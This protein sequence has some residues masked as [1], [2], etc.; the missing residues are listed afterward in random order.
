MKKSRGHGQ[1]SSPYYIPFDID[2]R[3]AYLNSSSHRNAPKLVQMSK[4]T[5]RDNSM[6][7][8]LD[9]KS[10]KKTGFSSAFPTS[11]QVKKEQ[12]SVTMFDD[13]KAALQKKSVVYLQSQ[14][15]NFSKIA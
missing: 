12:N 4:A 7:K 11:T 10:R 6:Y 9:Q 3:D 8:N 5:P 13:A 14:I 15:E 2:I 1:N